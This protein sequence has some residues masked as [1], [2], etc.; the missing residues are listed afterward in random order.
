VIRGASTRLPTEFGVFDVTAY[1]DLENNAEHL[2]LHMGEVNGSAP[3]VRI[4]SSCLTGDVLGSCRCDCGEQLRLALKRIAGEKSG[5]LLYL[6]Q[7]GRGIGLANKIRVYALQDKGLDTVEANIELGFE[8]DERSYAVAG[9][10]LRDQG[11]RNI[12]LMTNN[13]QKISALEHHGV[14][15]EERVAHEVIPN[16]HNAS[17]LK[18]KAEKLGHLLNVI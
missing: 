14:A 13:P 17:Y 16:A 6:G 15:V 5:F 7:E 3:L 4:H 9:E 2:L 8:P 11:V 1:L 10:M 12:R 18:A